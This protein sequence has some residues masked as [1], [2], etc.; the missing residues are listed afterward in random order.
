MPYYIILSLVGLV[1]LF[2]WLAGAVRWHLFWLYVWQLKNYHLGRFRAYF[3]T[4]NGKRALFNPIWWIK[5]ILLGVSVLLFGSIFFYEKL[6]ALGF[7][8]EIL[9]WAIPLIFLFYIFD[10]CRSIILFLKKKIKLPKLTNKMCFLLPIV[11]LPLGVIAVVLAKLLITNIFAP[12]IGVTLILVLLFIPIILIFDLLT[13][14]IVSILVMLFQPITVLLRNR[15]LKKAIAKRETLENLL[16][17]GVTGSYGK[18]SVKEFLRIILGESFKVVATEKNINS[19]IG[20]AETILDKVSDEHEIFICEMG[21]YNRGGIKLL[22][23]ITKPKIGVLT[24]ISNQHLATFGS[25]KNIIRAKFELI[26]SLP[27]EGLA[28]L[29]WDSSLIRDNF[30][31]N[32][33]SIKYGFVKQ[34]D[35]DLWTENVQVEKF[36]V[37]FDVVFKAG[38][39][40]KFQLPLIGAQSILN[41]LPALA[42][43]KRLGMEDGEISRGSAKINAQQSGLQITKNKNNFFVANASYSSNF[44]G[45]L[46]H[47]EYLKIWD[48]PKIFVMPCLIELGREGPQ[49]HFKIGKKIGEVCDYLIVVTADYFSELKR[50]ALEAGMNPDH[51]FLIKNPVMQYQ[52]I[53]E[54]AAPEGIVFLEGRVSNELLKKLFDFG[55]E[56]K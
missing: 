2:F 37:S 41:F 49:T 10:G 12:S 17:I 40:M 34:E 22:T 46:A 36:S 11:F 1:V 51:I 42:I 24:G 56:D 47:L 32:L 20:I 39:R 18:S 28:V 54:L 38:E 27:D 14:L 25:Q 13:P 35:I 21:A 45:V 4:D 8:P 55:P 43:A 5:L 29:N 48:T 9:V 23:K 44:E 26:E 50:G 15:I 31:N 33:N 6:T 30:Q 16:V 7:K 3:S 53:I 19:E 52:K